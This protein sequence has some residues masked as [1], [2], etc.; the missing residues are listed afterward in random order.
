MQLY[1]QLHNARGTKNRA[2]AE[3]VYLYIS[4]GQNVAEAE[5]KERVV[6]EEYL[7]RA[8]THPS[9]RGHPRAVTVGVNVNEEGVIYIVIISERWLFHPAC[10]F[11]TKCVLCSERVQAADPGFPAAPSSST[12][13]YYF[14]S[15]TNLSFQS[16][17]PFHFTHNHQLRNCSQCLLFDI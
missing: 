12:K 6:K 4:V 17:A 13:M 5:G 15:G 10:K 2:E 14:R 3:K 9:C 16:R 8:R 11:C 1:V 7:I